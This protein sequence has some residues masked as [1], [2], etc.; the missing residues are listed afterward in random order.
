MNQTGRLTLCCCCMLIGLAGC[1]QDTPDQTPVAVSETPTPAEDVAAAPEP[2]EAV[3]LPSGL[4]LQ[5][6]TPGDGEPCPE[7]ATVE[8]EYTAMLA[9]GT[10]W[11]STEKRQR[12]M[13]WD[14][15]ESNLIEGLRRG[16]VGMKPGGT[17]RLTI[18]AAMAYGDRGRPPI[19]PKEEL[20]FEITL[21]GWE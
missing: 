1:E 19:P 13:T 7:G 4:V 2:A 14:L 3:T 12:A 9:D 5:D 11:D 15:S 16:V 20:T 18:P 6:L 8:V 10:I 17:R 21:I